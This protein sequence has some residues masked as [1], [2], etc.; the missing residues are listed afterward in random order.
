MGNIRLVLII[1]GLALLGWGAYFL[2]KKSRHKRLIHSLELELFS[3]QLARSSKKEGEPK[4]IKEEINASEQLYSALSSLKTPFILEAAVHHIGEDIHFYIGVHRDI[5]ESV[6]KQIQSIWPDAQVKKA[7][8]YN[9]FNS[10]GTVAALY[11]AQKENY[12]LPIRTYA[13]LEADSFSQIVG[14]LSRLDEIGEGAAIQVL[15][16]PAPKSAKK[17]IQNALNRLKE[18]TP[19]KDIL[20]TVP[21]F[22]DIAKSFAQ[23]KN[24]KEPKSK[25]IDESAVKA[26]EAKIAK[27]LFLVNVRLIASS[28]NKMHADAIV[29]GLM[30]GFSQFSAPFRNNF[31]IVKPRNVDKLAYQFAFREFH[32]SQAIIVNSEEMASFFHLPTGSTNIPRIKWLKAKEAAPPTNLPTSGIFIGETSFRGESKPVFILDEDRRRHVYIVGQ[33]GTGKSTI[34]YNM[35]MKD[36]KDGK[37]VAVLDPNGDLI[38]NLLQAI[39]E[40]RVDDLIIFDPGDL[41]RPLGLNML[42]YDPAKPEQRSFIV[43]ELMLIFDR[44]FDMKLVGGPMF[45]RYASNALFLLMDDPEEGATLVDV[46]RVFTDSD[47]RNR[48][49]A[50]CKNPLVKDFWEKEASKVKGEY[51][52]ENTAPYFTSKFNSFIA[53]DYMRPIIAQPKSVF[54]FRDVMDEGKILLVNLSKGKIGELGSNLLGMIITGKLQMAAFS[55][56][57]TTGENARRDFYMYIDEFQNFTTDSIATILAEARKYRLNLIVAHQYVAQLTEKIRDAVFGNVGTSI[58]FRVGPPDAET[59]LKLFEPTFNQNDLINIDN[60]NAYTRLLI[61]GGTSRPFNIK[62]PLTYIH[63]PEYAAKLKE[64][65][66]LKYGRPREEVEQRVYDRLRD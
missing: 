39:P 35:A 60:L 46:P 34:I 13:E 63:N 4:N 52:L 1:A 19:L 47:F 42:E 65:N 8:D 21:T 5:A 31:K 50:K 48:L 26:F 9:I 17:S 22:G 37:G 43:D 58:A 15:V 44:L 64:M 23:K 27:P 62:I 24:E 38:E 10:H 29:D 28:P 51:S 11:V 45:L 18:G 66:S 33:T 53:N 20:K 25:I 14:G 3:V 6:A 49:V 7:S 41:A 61:S 32:D 59:L 40:K 36:I 54:K 16:K 12:A 56:A 30:T 2:Y 55:R 57:D